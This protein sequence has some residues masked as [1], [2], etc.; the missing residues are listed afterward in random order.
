MIEFIKKIRASTLIASILIAAIVIC[1]Q[2]L[3]AFQLLELK[4]LDKLF[5]LRPSEGMDSQIVMITFDDNDIA[6]IGTWPFSDLVVTDL[7]T[8]VLGSNPQVIGLDVYRNLPVEQGFAELK[9]VFQST[10]NLIVVEKFV[11]PSV[12]PPPYVDYKNQVGFVDTVVDQDGAVRRGLLS[13]AKPNGDVI[14]SF[15]IKTALKYLESQKIY[16][17]ISSEE[18]SAITIGKSK[19]FP[20]DSYQSG[21]GSLDNGG[22]QVLLNYRCHTNCFQ[23]I[24]MTNVLEGKYS[25]ELFENKIVLIGSTAESLRDFFFSPYEDKIPGVYVHAN[26]ISQIVN[27]AISKRPF[28]QTYPKWLEGIGILVWSAIGV[29]GIFRFLKGVN[30]G[31]NQFIIGI[32]AF[33]LTSVLVTVLISY[34]SF[35]NSF[36]LPIFPLLCSFLLSSAVCIIQLS[37]KFRYASNID[38]LTQ[39]ANRRYFDRF[40]MKNFQAKQE[41]SVLICDVDHFKL[42]NDSYGHQMGDKCLKQVAQ[43]INKSVRSGELAGRYGGEEFAVI[44]PNTNYESAMVVAE[45]IVTNV[46][47]LNIP[48][49]SSKTTNIVTLSCGFAS[50]ESEDTSSL[51]LLV[52]ADRALYKAKEQG[53]N[54]AVGYKHN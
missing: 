32:T 11:H 9:R 53:R 13:I 17:V 4:F 34:I 24:S 45:R 54:T 38:E 18:K 22:Y 5:Q 41:L 10:P 27:G 14:H 48:H 50:M 36:W 35:L 26:L 40:L 44:L 1:M 3:G 21:Y 19:F 42:Y 51:D 52:K 29:K 16:P 23:A 25:K 49:K 6:N 28:L 8:K 46:R 33:I 31:K 47:N 2:V 20:L 39:I 30:L 43:A 15:S 37:E 12:P 7:V